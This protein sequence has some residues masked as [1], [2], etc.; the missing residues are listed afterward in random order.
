MTEPLMYQMIAI[1][2]TNPAAVNT[3]K[4]ITYKSSNKKAVKVSTSGKVTVLKYAKK[5]VTITVKVGTVKKTFSVK[6]IK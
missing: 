1:K 6:V 5:K 2:I 4:K 3:T